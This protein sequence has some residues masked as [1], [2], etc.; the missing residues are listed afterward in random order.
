MA[1]LL[2]LILVLPTFHPSLAYQQ[3]SALKKAS[4]L[5]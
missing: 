5:A 3:L 4:L 1:R 2:I